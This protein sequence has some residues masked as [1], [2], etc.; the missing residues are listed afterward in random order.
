MFKLRKTHKDWYEDGIEGDGDGPQ[1]L[2][3]L[4]P[5]PDIQVQLFALPINPERGEYAARRLFVER[6]CR[7]GDRRVYYACKSWPLT[8]EYAARLLALG[9]AEASQALADKLAEVMALPNMP[10]YLD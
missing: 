8:D 6:D 1:Q 2:W 7:R 5:S 10:E 3:R 9:N 4:D